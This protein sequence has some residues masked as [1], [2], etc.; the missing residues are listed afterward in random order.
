[1][2]QTPQTERRGGKTR[3]LYPLVAVVC[4]AALLT[5]PVVSN[6]IGQISQSTLLTRGIDPKGPTSTFVLYGVDIN[7]DAVKNG[8]FKLVSDF[9]AGSFTVKDVD[10]VIFP[11]IGAIFCSDK[12]VLDRLTPE[13]RKYIVDGKVMSSKEFSK[14]TAAELC[15]VVVSGNSM[16]VKTRNHVDNRFSYTLEDAIIAENK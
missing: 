11:R 10:G 8:N 6:A 16:N 13:I 5:C 2:M 1:M 9:E 15:K 12:K 14:V 3:V 7:Q 4:A